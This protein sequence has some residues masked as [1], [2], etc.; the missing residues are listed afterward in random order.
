MLCAR[1]EQGSR[2][3]PLQERKKSPPGVADLYCWHQT[4]AI[5]LGR[6]GDERGQNFEIACTSEAA[7]LKLV[8]VVATLLS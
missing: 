4:T 3:A 8:I 7:S 1:T 5:T 2:L 6:G